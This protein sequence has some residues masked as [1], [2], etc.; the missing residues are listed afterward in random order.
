MS[1]T[2]N[3]LVLNTKQ[4]KK[5]LFKVALS[6]GIDL[7]ITIKKDDDF[8]KWY[9]QVLEKSDLISYSEI[10]G[11]YVFKPT[12][13]SIWE[14]IQR[15]LDKLIKN[16]GVKNAYFPCFIPKTNLMKEK[17]N[18]EGFSP[19]VAWVTHSG[20]TKLD[21]P[22]AVRPTSETIIYPQF[23]DWIKSHKD[24]PLRINQWCNAVRWEMKH[25]IPFIRS[26]EFLW[27]EGHSAFATKEE[28]DAE[29]LKILEFYRMVYEDFLAI[30]VTKGRK[31]EN[32]KFAG[33]DYTTTIEGLVTQNG[34]AIQCATSHSL[35]Q[36]FS[37]VFQIK[38]ENKLGEKSLVW[39]NSWGLSTRTI[40]VMIMVHGD[41]KGLVLPPKVAEIQVVIVC[42]PKGDNLAI[43][44]GNANE[45][46]H[47]LMNAGIRCMVDDSDNNPGWKYNY[48]ETKGIPFRIELGQRELDNH[49]V[50]VCRRD[51]FQKIPI[52]WID[53]NLELYKLIDDMHQ[54]LYIK[55]KTMKENHTKM[56]TTFSEFL[57][58]LNAKN[59]V[60]VPFCGKCDCEENIKIKS[61][62]DTVIQQT[63]ETL[64]LTG[65][66]NVAP[67]TLKGSAKSL[68]IPFQQP[69]LEFGTKCFGE[70]GTDAM[71]WCLFGRSY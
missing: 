59:I 17:E 41:D 38:F 50:M 42:V 9:I 3:P 71:D 46:K 23:A 40:G 1:E 5:G 39:Q 22:L 7:G 69:F 29:V 66:G 11:C 18:F 13:Y 10:S 35:G 51:N 57:T 8:S 60:L 15:F 2:N 6:K 48:W 64:E 14:N 37:K 63:D 62:G 52:K 70:C 36:N 4:Q 43:L 24:L 16:D 31:S 55:A 53:L 58:L 27:Q 33:A 54:K 28:A 20:D 12:S 44:N 21:M 47:S 19:E 45:L 67:V 34:R 26:R 32:E 30:P 68:C 49:S 25:C 61:K 65:S 56:A